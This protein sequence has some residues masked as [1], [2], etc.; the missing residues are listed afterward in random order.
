M[1]AL[2]QTAAGRC[3][4]PAIASPMR[5]A[6]IDDP[7]AP[8][9]AMARATASAMRRRV[10]ERARAAQASSGIPTNAGMSAVTLT[11]DVSA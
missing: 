6:F 3:A 10:A 4:V 9:S 5:S 8:R 2:T 11:A 7:S 1:T